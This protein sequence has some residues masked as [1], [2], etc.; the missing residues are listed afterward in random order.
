LKPYIGLAI[1][2]SISTTSPSNPEGGPNTIDGYNSL[3]VPT[4]LTLLSLNGLTTKSALL[5]IPSYIN[6]SQHSY[7]VRYKI[8]ND[9]FSYFYDYIYLNEMGMYSQIKGSCSSSPYKLQTLNAD[10]AS[11]VLCAQLCLQSEYCNSFSYEQ[12]R[13]CY[14]YSTISASGSNCQFYSKQLTTFV[15]R[16]GDV[17]GYKACGSSSQ[18]LSTVS[19]NLD[20]Y[21][22]TPPTYAIGYRYSNL[23]GFSKWS[24]DLTVGIST[25][26]SASFSNNGNTVL[27]FKIGSNLLSGTDIQ[28]LVYQEGYLSNT[29]VYTQAVTLYSSSQSSSL[30]IGNVWTDVYT[31]FDNLNQELT[32]TIKYG[33]VTWASI[34]NIKYYPVSS[35]TRKSLTSTSTSYQFYANPNQIKSVRIIITQKY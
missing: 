28:I 21:T 10:I 30:V 4:Q 13:K 19:I 32:F 17:L 11:I 7:Q 29:L 27:Q 9:L 22:F 1:W 23:K 5:N 3:S 8:S 34:S 16:D 18:Y 25:T 33:A 35:V 15:I 2:D 12:D 26:I 31:N 24:S 20:S 6:P 14:F